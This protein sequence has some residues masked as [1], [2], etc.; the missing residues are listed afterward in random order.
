MI[1]CIIVTFDSYSPM[2]G[3][4]RAKFDNKAAIPFTI[5]VLYAIS[6]L[7][8]IFYNQIRDYVYVCGNS[9]NKY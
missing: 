9:M 2:S 3:K 5:D 6:I 1:K 4:K 7:E 8:N